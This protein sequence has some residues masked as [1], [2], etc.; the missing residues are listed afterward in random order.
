[1]P[2]LIYLDLEGM[3][4]IV[5]ALFTGAAP[6]VMD[7]HRHAVAQQRRRALPSACESQRDLLLITCSCGCL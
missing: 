1:M 4:M 7:E 5:A 2:A 3:A 6:V